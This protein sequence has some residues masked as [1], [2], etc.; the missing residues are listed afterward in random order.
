VNTFF[1]KIFK[2]RISQKSVQLEPSCSMR[3]DRQTD[4]PDKANSGFLRLCKQL[5]KKQVLLQYR[6]RVTANYSD[7]T[8]TQ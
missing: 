3:T 6:I 5:E 8:F 4:R 1:R 2:Y 7:K